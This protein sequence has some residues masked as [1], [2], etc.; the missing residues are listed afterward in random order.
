MNTFISV[1][2]LIECIEKAT[3]TITVKV[4]S[5]EWGSHLENERIE[6]ICPSDLVFLLQ[7]ATAGFR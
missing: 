3:Q 4:D 2:T 1:Q 7:R 6:I 5:T